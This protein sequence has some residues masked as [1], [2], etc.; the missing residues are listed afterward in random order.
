MD[1]KET[2][3]GAC[4]DGGHSSVCG[5]G[6]SHWKHL[7]IKIAIAIFI[8]WCGIQFGELRAM[9]RGAYQGYGP[10]TGYS[11]GMMRGY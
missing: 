3:G 2:R 1:A 4:C 10:T 9:L 11:G 8:F 7:I 5:M 6:G